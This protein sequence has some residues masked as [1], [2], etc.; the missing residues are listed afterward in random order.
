M[1]IFFIIA[2]KE[3]P[4][5]RHQL[6]KT[7]LTQPSVLS[8]NYHLELVPFKANSFVYI[9]WS[10]HKGNGVKNNK[11]KDIFLSLRPNRKTIGLVIVRNTQ[12]IDF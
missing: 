7:G 2:T 10:K 11:G 1:S 4:I 8:T 5:I 6:E 9:V 12:Q 3:L